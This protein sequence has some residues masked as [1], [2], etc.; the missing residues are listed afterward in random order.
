MTA[1]IELVVGS[2]RYAG[3]K[4]VRVTRSIESIAGSFALDVSDRWGDG[5]LWPIAEEDVCRVLIDG[6]TV[7]DGF[8]DKRS[9]SAAKDSDRSA[10]P[11]RGAAGNAR[12]EKRN[13]RL[14]AWKAKKAAGA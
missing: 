13:A 9:L 2:L 3:W 11:R 1:T 7:L 6:E 12:A 10:T 4:S 5:E 8:V 14:E